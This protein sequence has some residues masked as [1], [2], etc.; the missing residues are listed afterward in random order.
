MTVGGPTSEARPPRAE[1]LASALLAACN[2]DYSVAI[3][4]LR[5]TLD[6]LLKA[7]RTGL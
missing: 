1:V 4:L 7:Q 6:V 3:R 5:R 2:G